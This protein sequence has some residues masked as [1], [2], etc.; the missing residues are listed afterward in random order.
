MLRR[1]GRPWV[2]GALA[3]FALASSSVPVSGQTGTGVIEGTVSDAGSGRKL[4]NA[5][6]VVGSS[7]IGAVSTDAGTFRIVGA[8]LGPVIL[9]VHLIG[10]AP[11]SKTVTVVAGEPAHVAF[12]MSQSAIS[13]SDVV[14]TGTGGAVQ[15]KKLGNTV[16]KVNVSELKNAPINSVDE[17]LQGRVPGVSMLPT[18]GVTGQGA[19][20]RIRGNASLSQSNNPIIYIDG[21]RADNGGGFSGTNGAA[22]SRLDDLDPGAIDHVEILKGAAAATLYGTEASNGVIQIFTKHGNTSAP[23]W[24]IDATGTSSN[25][26]TNRLAPN[27]GF[28]RTQPQADS[29]STLFGRTITPFVPFSVGVLKKLF[30]TGYGGQV[31]GSVDGGSDKVTYFVSGRY[32]GENGPFTS[33]P[34]NGNTKNNN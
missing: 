9:N 2:A 1:T 17:I 8:P 18:S 26:P 34:F 27:S 20:I 31:G 25:Y 3:I 28:A 5:Q 14:V 23:H 16:A 6:V 12:V 11:T 4:S 29:L 15:E 21:V 24:T 13:L 33:K 32:L 22:P 7:R 30:D 19:T 10:Y